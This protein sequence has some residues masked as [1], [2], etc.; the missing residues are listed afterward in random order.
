MLSY[1]CD[2]FFFSVN[3][4]Y[5]YVHL[6]FVQSSRHV[7]PLKLKNPVGKARNV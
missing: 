3:S 4:L 6:I 2:C 7:E 5:L 1:N